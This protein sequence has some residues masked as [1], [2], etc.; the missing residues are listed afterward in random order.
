MEKYLYLVCDD[1][2]SRCNVKRP[3]DTGLCNYH[4]KLAEYDRFLLKNLSRFCL[5][6][7]TGIQVSGDFDCL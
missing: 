3:S 5:K 1:F 7:L 6:M 2:R 4:F